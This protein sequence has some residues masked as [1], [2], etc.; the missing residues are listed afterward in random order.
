MIGP[1]WAAFDQRLA[2]SKASQ[3][4]SLGPAPLMCVFQRI[5]H[6][7]CPAQLSVSLLAALGKKAPMR[8]GF[9]F[10]QRMCKTHGEEAHNVN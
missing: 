8:T 4:A 1:P 7:G 10:Y 6:N 2:H 9:R 3:M 5:P